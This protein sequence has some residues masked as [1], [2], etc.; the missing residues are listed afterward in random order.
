MDDAWGITDGYFDIAGVW[1]E[2]TD[3]VR[4]RLRAVMGE[5]DDGPPMWF[6]GAGDTPL[7]CRL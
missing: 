4:D 5:P 7:Q 1:H 6:V 2:T 3:R